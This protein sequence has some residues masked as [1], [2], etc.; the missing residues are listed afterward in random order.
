MQQAQISL[1]PHEGVRVGG[2]D[3]VAPSLQHDAEAAGLT[4]GD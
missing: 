4:S 1:E 3:G 2:G